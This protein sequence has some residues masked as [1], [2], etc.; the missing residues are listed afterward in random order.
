MQKPTLSTALSIFNTGTSCP[1]TMTLKEITDILKVRHNDA[2]KVVENM[3]ESSDFGA[4]RKSR[5][6]Y[7]Q[8][9]QTTETY[10]L[11]K[12]QS[13][14][15]AAKL[16]TSLLMN[17]IDRWQ[18]LEGAAP[19]P[20]TQIEQVRLLLESLEANEHLNDLIAK[21]KY[22][23]CTQM[24]AK[25]PWAKHWWKGLQES[26]IR[27]GYNVDDLPKFAGEQGELATSVIQPNMYPI[28]VYESY[29]AD[30]CAGVPKY[31]KL[32]ILR[33][34]TKPEYIDI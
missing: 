30:Q 7:N 6:A 10:A 20:L 12:R 1:L 18:E 15:V 29:I 34:G 21:G 32:K 5:I 27:D 26:C 31:L 19:K 2:M 11:D 8:H 28:E 13:I 23:T 24:R 3:A 4:L 16:N 14:A 33:N 22:V 9:G 25:Y 17:I